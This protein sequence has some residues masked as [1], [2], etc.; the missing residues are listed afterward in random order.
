V[1]SAVANCPRVRARL[2]DGVASRGSCTVSVGFAVLWH[3]SA[4]GKAII[5]TSTEGNV[6][7]L[8]RE[9]KVGLNVYRKK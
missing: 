4:S 5:I 9:E 1:I 6:S 8:D 2:T 7:V 3:P